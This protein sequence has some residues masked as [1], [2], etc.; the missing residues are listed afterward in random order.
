M[1]EAVFAVEGGR[2][3]SRAS[4]PQLGSLTRYVDDLVLAYS[5]VYT[6]EE[7]RALLTATAEALPE[8]HRFRRDIVLG[9]RTSA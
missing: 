5:G 6:P 4:S 8:L 7:R 9:E 2:L 1:F 3:S